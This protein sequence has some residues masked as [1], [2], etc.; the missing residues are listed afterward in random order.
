MTSNVLRTISLAELNQVD[1]KHVKQCDACVNK[2]VL[3][4]CTW[5]RRYYPNLTIAL[6]EVVILKVYRVVEHEVELA[7]RIVHEVEKYAST[8]EGWIS[9]RAELGTFPLQDPTSNPGCRQSAEG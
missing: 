5:Q 4:E 3:C 7:H 2:C 8:Q 6:H 1:Q 9:P